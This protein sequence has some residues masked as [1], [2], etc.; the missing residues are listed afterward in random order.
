MY[1]NSYIV[2]NYPYSVSALTWNVID[3]YRTRQKHANF[4]SRPYLPSST[5]AVCHLIHI[6]LYKPDPEPKLQENLIL[7]PNLAPRNGITKYKQSTFPTVFRGPVFREEDGFLELNPKFFV[8]WVCLYWE[9]PSF[10][11]TAFKTSELASRCL[12]NGTDRV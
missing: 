10:A 6:S 12:S 4:W 5:S 2:R 1:I 8:G 3:A 11:V 7:P 9:K